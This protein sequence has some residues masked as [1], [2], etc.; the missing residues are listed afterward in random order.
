MKE[1]SSL[2]TKV[3]YFSAG[4]QVGQMRIIL[5]KKNGTLFIFS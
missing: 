3:F 5:E 2:N 1:V 4:E